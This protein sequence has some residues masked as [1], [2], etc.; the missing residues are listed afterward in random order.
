MKDEANPIG[1]VVE[2][3]AIDNYI[4]EL[5]KEWDESKETV[6]WYK[7]WYNISMSRVT[8][9]IMDALDDLVCY[10]DGVVGQGADKKATVLAAV[11]K[12]YD[13]VIKEA[14][15]FPLKPFAGYVKD[16]VINHI[17]SN[18][19]DWMV[20]KYRAGAWRMKDENKV[21]ALWAAGNAAGKI[22]K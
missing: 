21:Q 15:P 8:N 20:D 7:L 9:F 5:M 11:E 12:I 22:G 16:Y 10:I 6:P 2:D 4:K 3:S 19:I 18:A 17:I 13:H 14:L 1:Q